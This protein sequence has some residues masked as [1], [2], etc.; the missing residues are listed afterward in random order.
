[1][2]V[3]ARVRRRA[4]AAA[5]RTR[6]VPPARAATAPGSAGLLRHGVLFAAHNAQHKRR[7]SG[8]TC[9]EVMSSRPAAPARECVNIKMNNL[10]VITATILGNAAIA[11]QQSD[12]THYVHMHVR[13]FA[14][15]NSPL[16]SWKGVLIV[17]LNLW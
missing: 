9:F 10:T 17:N 8:A 5:W 15:V 6:F 4:A 2:A 3:A 1:M 13:G 14:R 11:E 7:A 12:S 16:R